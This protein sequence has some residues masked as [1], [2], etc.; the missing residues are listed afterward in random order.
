MTSSD[1]LKKLCVCRLWSSWVTC[2]ILV[3]AGRARKATIAEIKQSRFLQ[4][5]DDNFLI[6]I[7]ERMMKGDALLNFMLLK[8]VVGIV[9]VR[10]C[11]SCSYHEIVEFRMVRGESK[12]KSSVPNL[13]LKKSDF[14]YLCL[15]KYH[16]M[17]SWRE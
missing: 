5:S 14:G 10:D 6:E 16:R 2:I 15:D 3:F 1:N 7:L 17:W 9:E 13:N 4:C 11:L 8:E 12:A